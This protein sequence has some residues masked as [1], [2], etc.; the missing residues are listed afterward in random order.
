MTRFRLAAL[1]MSTVSGVAMIPSTAAAQNSVIYACVRNASGQ[2]RIV[3]SPA[4]CSKTE[5]AVQWSVIGAQGPAGEV[6]PQG[7]IGPAGPV[8]SP[9]ATGLPGEIGPEGPQGVP[10]AQGEPGLA[11][12]SGAVTDAL[13]VGPSM[14]GSAFATAMQDGINYC[15]AGFHPAN[16]WE[17]MVLD[18][19][20]HPARP[21]GVAS[22]VIGGFPNQESHLRSLTNGQSNVVCE[23]GSYLSKYP[24]AL[25]FGAIQDLTGGLHCAPAEMVLPTLCAR[26]R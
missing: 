21:V 13:R 26:N 25:T 7:P 19:L 22:W 10:G 2:V 6:G 17:A 1:V 15:D 8:G 14:T 12:A 20:S 4:A 16:A 5:V 23:S 11:G 3:A 9:G 24:S 18:I